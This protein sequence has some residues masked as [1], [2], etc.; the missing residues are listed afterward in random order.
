MAIDFTI[1]DN[2]I[3]LETSEDIKTLDTD[4]GIY[5]LDLQES[6]AVLETDDGTEEEFDVTDYI[7]GGGGGSS[8]YEELDNYLTDEQRDEAYNVYLNGK[9]ICKGVL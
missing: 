8:D 4:E 3:S 1:D 9:R 5:D 6:G 2:N 7:R